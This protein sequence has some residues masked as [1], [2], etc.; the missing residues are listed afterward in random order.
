M[1]EHRHTPSV[2]DSLVERVTTGAQRAKKQIDSLASGATAGSAPVRICC[3]RE[4]RLARSAETELSGFP[5]G[6][7]P[8]DPE[9]PGARVSRRPCR[10]L[11]CRSSGAIC[12]RMTAVCTRPT[13]ANRADQEAA[14]CAARAD[15]LLRNGPH[16][17]PSSRSPPHHR[18]EHGFTE[19]V[20]TDNKS[21]RM[22]VATEER[23]EEWK[24]R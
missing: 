9:H 3:L 11:V 10:A 12:M 22:G 1:S 20:S 8:Q 4:R 7:G 23:G 19:S 14:D 5:D 16:Q 15:L 21:L 24:A 2:I 13:S 17:H 18:R 6:G